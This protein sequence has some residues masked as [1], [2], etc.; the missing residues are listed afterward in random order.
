VQ[1]GLHG[2]VSLDDGPKGLS[3][4]K[5]QLILIN[6][7][8]VHGKHSAAV[9]SPPAHGPSLVEAVPVEKAG[10]VERGNRQ[11]AWRLLCAELEA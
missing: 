4:P 9:E 7:V 5:F 11:R 3:A 2:I 10:L 8:V 1:E 6:I